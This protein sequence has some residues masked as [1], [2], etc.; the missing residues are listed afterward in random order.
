MK[1]PSERHHHYT[2]ADY[3]AYEDGSNVKH[4]FFDGEIYAMAG[5]TPEHAA[6]AA[7]VTTMIGAQ[8][9]EGPCR[10]FS[11]DLKI[12]VLATG[13]VSYPDV[14]VVCGAVQHDPESRMVVV[15][16]TVIVEVLS[17]GTEEWDRGKK[18]EHYKRIP[19]LRDFVLVSHRKPE[20]ELWRREGGD[21]WSHQT[22][23]AG[24]T[25][26]I[27]SIGGSLRVDDIYRRALGAADPR[28][29]SL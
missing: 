11:S 20:L 14:T 8:L 10:V 24:G 16:P 21:S 12:R 13:L 3:L 5:G 18:L 1:Q 9:G 29:G 2:F 26:E 22:I 28:S 23:G 6:L 4:E 27:Q 15:N 7:A 25:V 17:D 19:S